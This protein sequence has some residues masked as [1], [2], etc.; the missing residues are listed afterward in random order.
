MALTSVSPRAYEF[1]RVSDRVELSIVISAYNEEGAIGETVSRIS[2][3][4]SKPPTRFE[5][6]VDDDGS[7]DGTR[8]V[9]EL[10]D[11]VV[12]SSAEKA[13]STLPLSLRA[14]E[15]HVVED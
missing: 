13:W 15:A 4:L 3:A 6:F 10:S 12:L 9:A 2:L 8:A 11:A 7:T 1:K 14:F 5:I